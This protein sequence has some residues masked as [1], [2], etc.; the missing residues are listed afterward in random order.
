[1]NYELM[2]L[3]A[4][5]Y[6]IAE[7]ITEGYTWGASDNIFEIEPRTYHI[8]RLIENIGIIGL[9]LVFV[10]VNI[11]QIL[12]LV[13]TGLALYEMAFC[14]IRYGNALY[15]KTS[16]WFGIPHPPGKFW[17]WVLIIGIGIYLMVG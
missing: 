16:K 4:M 10:F 6:F 13:I 14:Y 1:M 2:F 9:V 12:A 8:Y 7:G 17:V 3:F 5:I 11:W 15:N